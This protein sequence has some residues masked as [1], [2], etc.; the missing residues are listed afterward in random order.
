MADKAEPLA[1]YVRVLRLLHGA[2]NDVRDMLSEDDRAQME[3]RNLYA[4]EDAIKA[5]EGMTDTEDRRWPDP[6]SIWESPLGQLLTGE[7]GGQS[8]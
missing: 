4:A 7:D 2:I 5:L 1:D 3:W 6:P 8:A